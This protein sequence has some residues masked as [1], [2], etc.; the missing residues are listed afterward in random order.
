MDTLSD[1]LL[2]T[3]SSDLD[4]WC[5]LLMRMVCERFNSFY[6]SG[7]GLN[8]IRKKVCCL[9]RFDVSS[10]GVRWL[11]RLLK[12]H[13]N[14]KCVGFTDKFNVVLNEDGTVTG[15][16]YVNKARLNDI[17]AISCGDHHT[18]VLTGDTKKVF[19]FQ[20]SSM[21]AITV[22]EDIVRI[23]SAPHCIF[24]IT[25]LECGG[26]VYVRGYGDKGQLGLG[27]QFYSSTEVAR[28]PHLKNIIQIS[29][30]IR[31]TLAL[32]HEGMVYSFGGDGYHGELG[33]REHTDTLFPSLITGLNNIVQVAAG[34]IHSLVLTVDGKVY[35][36]GYNM[37]GQLGMG[38]LDYCD[39]PTLIHGLD[40]V[41]QIAAGIHHSLALTIEGLVYFFGHDSIGFFSTE[42]GY[43]LTPT[44]VPGVNNAVNI[45]SVG[46]RSAIVMGNGEVKIFRADDDFESDSEED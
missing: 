27:N 46:F 34:G 41:V 14:K 33:P 1:E 35:G 3:I 19:Q 7:V 42:E 30:L 10:M 8:V 28:I 21:R 44:L 37:E 45:S 9:T 22:P 31:H 18:S 2:L 38:E 12:I 15:D 20:S 17:T 32:T 25:S 29:S 39:K 16:K 26:S 4:V 43:F 23:D 36:F 5:L 40:H 13:N 24:M 11:I 6:S